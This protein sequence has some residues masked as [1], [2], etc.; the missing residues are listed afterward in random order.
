MTRIFPFCT[1]LFIN[2]QNKL[3]SSF[4]AAFC[5]KRV[6]K[7]KSHDT[8]SKWLV[9]GLSK[10]SKLNDLIALSK[11]PGTLYKENKI[12]VGRF[13]KMRGWGYVII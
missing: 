10:I 13:K 8:S 4:D 1:V 3:L 2:T 11:S 12:K 9:L 5:R 7:F 6:Q